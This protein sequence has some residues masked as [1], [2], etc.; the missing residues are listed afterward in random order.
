MTTLNA[1]LSV[2]YKPHNR[3]S[4]N[5]H[6]SKDSPWQDLPAWQ[7]VMWLSTFFM[8]RQWGRLH[9]LTSPF[10]CSLRWHLCAWSRRT[11]CCWISFRFSGS[12]V[13]GAAPGPAPTALSPTW[14]PPTAATPPTDTPPT[15]PDCW[16]ACGERIGIRI[17]YLSQRKVGF[18]IVASFLKQM[19]DSV[20]WR[21]E[22]E[23]FAEWFKGL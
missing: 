21:K 22:V 18:V 16:D 23:F 20:V 7:W 3:K 19:C 11:S 13:G 12:A 9:C 2:W 1:A 6:N 10:A 8:V 15:A 17:P 14:G 4:S 5:H